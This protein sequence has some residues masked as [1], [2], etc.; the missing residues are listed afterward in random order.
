[1]R[2]RAGDEDFSRIIDSADLPDHVGGVDW[3]INAAPLTE[4]T[5][6]LFDARIF[7]AMRTSA[8]FVSIGRGAST[9]THDLLSALEEGTIAGAG[10]DVVDP[11]PLPRDHPLWDAPNTL[12]TA[13][14]SGDT[15]G[16]TDRLAQ[17]F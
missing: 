2:E 12:I 14:L 8:R 16:W 15:E 4:A 7:E 17:Q 3:L 13:H 5:R 9:V 10:L 6:G 1:T 11:E